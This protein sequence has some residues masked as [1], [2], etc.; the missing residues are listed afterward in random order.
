MV[1][2]IPIFNFKNVYN[3]PFTKLMKKELGT[4]LAADICFSGTLID[5]SKITEINNIREV[6]LNKVPIESRALNLRVF[7][8][9]FS[10]IK[11]PS[12]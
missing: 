4:V 10:L 2:N 8:L 9:G 11:K 12:N 1:K 5:L 7:E 3:F 6:I